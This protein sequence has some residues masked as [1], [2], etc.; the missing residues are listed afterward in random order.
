MITKTRLGIFI[1]FFGYEIRIRREIK[2]DVKVIK[3]ISEK[4]CLHVN[5]PQGT[6]LDIKPS[7]PADADYWLLLNAKQEVLGKLNRE[8]EWVSF[9]NEV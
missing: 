2:A 3:A 5:F 1:N 4:L 8:L 9:G 7:L 6:P